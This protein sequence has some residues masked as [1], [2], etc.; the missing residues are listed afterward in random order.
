MNCGFALFIF[1]TENTEVFEENLLKSH[2]SLRPLWLIKNT[3][4]THIQYIFTLQ[5][6]HAQPFN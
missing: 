5:V 3:I 2:F 6:S 4:C 1:A